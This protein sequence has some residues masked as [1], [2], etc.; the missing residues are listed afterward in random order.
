M[1]PWITGG[2]TRIGAVHLSV[3]ADVLVAFNTIYL[4]ILLDIFRGIGRQSVTVILFLPPG[5]VPISVY[6]EGE[7]ETSVFALGHGIGTTGVK[8]I[9]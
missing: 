5:P 6:G 3:L 2:R 7:V 4:G 8:D 9:Q 1:H